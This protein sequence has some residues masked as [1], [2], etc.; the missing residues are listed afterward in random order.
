MTRKFNRGE[1]PVCHRRVSTYRRL[2]SDP[3]FV[4]H[5]PFGAGPA[6][7]DGWCAGSGSTVGELK[8]CRCDMS[9]DDLATLLR[10][11]LT[12]AVSDA[13]DKAFMDG[14]GETGSVTAAHNA[15][16]NV[17]VAALLPRLAAREQNSALVL[18]RIISDDLAL[19]MLSEAEKGYTR[20]RSDAIAIGCDHRQAHA[21]GNAV[22]AETVR[23]FLSQVGIADARESEIRSEGPTWQDIATAPRDVNLLLARAGTH[24]INR[25]WVDLDG[26]SQIVGGQWEPPHWQ[27]LPAPPREEGR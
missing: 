16:V 7:Y 1:C 21:A 24:L 22:K 9:S 12:P 3:K 25:G 10:E 26:L 14:G 2:G 13:A 20:A 4:N 8:P 17:I 23:S 19:Q 11:G 15:W 27:P 6:G 5:K 18:Q